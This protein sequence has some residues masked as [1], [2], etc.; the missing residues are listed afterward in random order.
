M[1]KLVN[2]FCSL[3]VAVFSLS[4]AGLLYGQEL[5]FTHFN[6]ED[7]ALAYNSINTIFED[8]RGYVWIGT[9]KGLSRYDGVRFKNYDKSALGLASD[10]VSAICED[11]SGNLWIGTDKGATLYRYDLDYFIPSD[12]LSPGDDNISE[13]VYIIKTDSRGV[14]W[15]GTRE[16][17]LYKYDAVSGKLEH[18]RLTDSS[19]ENVYRIEPDKAEGLFVYTYCDNIY[20][21][22]PDSGLSLL[23]PDNESYF[24]GDDIEGLVNAPGGLLYVASKRHGLCAVNLRSGDIKTLYRL[25]QGHRPLSLFFLDNRWLWMGSSCGLLQYDTANGSGIILSSDPSDSFSLSGDQ[26]TSVCSG[27]TNRL[28]VGTLHNGLNMFDPGRNVFRRVYRT[29]SSESLHGVSV[30]NF[31]EDKNHIVWVA[32]EK[33][34]LFQYNPATT[35]LLRYRTPKIIPQVLTSLC[36]EEDYLW[37]GAMNGIYKYSPKSGAVKVYNTFGI[38]ESESDNRVITFFRSSNGELLAGTTAG[39]VKYDRAKDS[40]VIVPGLA[41]L[42]VENI[43][44]DM[45]GDL[46]LASYASGLFRYDPKNAAVKKVYP[47]SGMISSVTIDPED[48]LW[49]IGFSD[50]FFRYNSDSDSF[51]G[52]NR[53]NHP[54]LP[55]D[56]LFNA[57][58]DGKGQLWISSDNGLVSYSKKDGSIRVYTEND[59]ILCNA[60]KKSALKLSDGTM[61]MGSEDGFIHFDPRDFEQES[62]NVH[63]AI[64]D[65]LIGG[66]SASP[67]DG[68]NPNFDVAQQ[69]NLAPNQASFEFLFSK[70]GVSGELCGRLLCRLK[71]Y[72]KQ[73]KDVSVQHAASWYNVPSGMYTL[74]FKMVNSDGWAYTPHSEVEIVVEPGFWRSGWGIALIALIVILSAAL[75]FALFYSRAMEKEKQKQA[76]REM[77]REK[78]TFNEK[79]AFFSGIVHEIKTPLTLI[80]TPLSKIMAENNLE[81]NLRKDLKVI[82][83][84]ADYMDHLVKELLEFV[85]VEKHGYDLVIKTIDIVEKLGF[86][87]F[88]FAES[89]KARNVR[90]TYRH[91]VESILIEADESALN[92]ILNNLLHNAVKYAESYIDVHVYQKDGQVSVTIRN[93]GPQIPPERREEIFK[94]FVQFSAETKPYSQSFGI[95]LSLARS[96]AELH[97]GCLYL[98]SDDKTCTKFVLRLPAKAVAKTKESV[99]LNAQGDTSEETKPLIMIAEDN[100]DLSSY[101]KSK[102]EEEFRIITAPSAETALS[103][104][105]KYDVDLLVTDIAMRNMS[106]IELCRKVNSDIE[107]SSIPVIVVSAISSDETKIECMKAGAVNYIEKPFNLDFLVSCMRSALERRA[108]AKKNMPPAQDVDIDI[109]RF[110]QPDGD[111]EFLRHFEIVIQENLGN[112]AFS[113]KQME[114]LLFM[115]HSTLNRKVKALLDTTPNEYLRDKRLDVAAQLLEN[116]ER[117]INEI[118]F[119]VGFN[120]PSYFSKCF[121]ERFGMLPAQYRQKYSS[122]GIEE[123]S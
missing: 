61:V 47:L 114:D 36:S 78:E 86:M 90:F 84:S 116:S 59:G 85:R 30:R 74:Q 58:D 37:I 65:M 46:W 117:R 1:K 73:W 57:L 79:M 21:F 83:D 25:P 33:S 35:E 53:A 72:E 76:E 6:K 54:L 63:V 75:L 32:T 62:R 122:S 23:L 38:E 49:V 52:I 48:R 119:S 42:A 118:C 34:G 108:A 5:H 93:D 80:Q 26:V 81:Q 13:K 12:T 92:K 113:N 44:E 20:R 14:V 41:G 15:L 17:G 77:L 29:S 28:W 51:T 55:S 111:T 103:M 102:L 10:F 105:R 24:A 11:Q 121:K 43:G 71:G 95:G 40:F 16:D 87:C 100:E 70:P 88:N 68:S 96:F 94:P 98:D 2:I 8:S 22:S 4:S 7:N 106:G 110:N 19:V 112:S 97:K 115:S 104:M 109:S 39:V 3:A 50:G 66:E 45:S 107:L 101:L 89:A 82:S 56:V 31:T 69:I 64:S 120:S 9:H 27:P 67:G 99:R 18:V 60:F 91:S 123:S